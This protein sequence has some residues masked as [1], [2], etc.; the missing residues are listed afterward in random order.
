MHGIALGN[1]ALV[2][3]ALAGLWVGAWALLPAAAAVLALLA[4]LATRGA[5]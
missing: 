4:W 1:A 3:C 2:A 5:A